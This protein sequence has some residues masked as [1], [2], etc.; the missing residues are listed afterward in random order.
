MSSPKKKSTTDKGVLDP[1]QKRI[2]FFPL[3]PIKSLLISD[4]EFK[5]VIKLG[6][7]MQHLLPV[8]P[9]VIEEVHNAKKEHE[10]KLNQMKDIT[11]NT[12]LDE[13]IREI[14][15]H[16]TGLEGKELLMIIKEHNIMRKSIE[17]DRGSTLQC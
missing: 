7:N 10:D 8:N 9:D 17:L 5:Y 2:Q 12:N 13:K 3:R 16:K 4:P 11:S 15:L 1:S 14:L 6:K